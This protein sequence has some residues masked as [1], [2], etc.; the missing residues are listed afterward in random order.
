MEISIRHAARME[1]SYLFYR[2]R[3]LISRTE[4][5]SI[6]RSTEH[7]SIL[8]P[9]TFC[10]AQRRDSIQNRRDVSFV[11]LSAFGSLFLEFAKERERDEEKQ[12]ERGG[13]ERKSVRGKNNKRRKR[14][15]ESNRKG[16]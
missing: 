9:T 10:P 13:R 15:S 1:R 7:F 14:C 12:K 4:A 2:E 3:F 5:L 6:D 16:M 8:I 11:V